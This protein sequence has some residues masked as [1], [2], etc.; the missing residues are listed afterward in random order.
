M[1]TRPHPTLP[2]AGYLR[3]LRPLLGVALAGALHGRWASATVVLCV[4][5]SVLTLLAFLAMAAGYE[6]QLNSRGQDDVALVLAREA[7]AES[8]SRVPAE[9]AR[10]I[11]RW[12]ATHG[13]APATSAELAITVS[14][15]RLRPA[16]G[17][18]ARANVPLRG[19]GAAGRSL[20]AGYRLA[21][22]REPAPGRQELMAGA[23][24][25]QELA[26]LAVGSRV[27][28]AGRDW[29]V[30]GHFELAGA[31]F[32]GELWADIGA[33]QAAYGRGNEL[34]SVR[35]A[36][37][38]PAE[39]EAALA[40]LDTMLAAEPGPALA[41]VTERA[42][43]ARQAEGTSRL[44]TLLAWPLAVLL[45]VG[46]VAG[47][48]ATLSMAVRSRRAGL[49]AL[50]QLGYSGLAVATSVVAE[51]L[52]LALAG[53]LLAFAI[54]LWWFDGLAARGLGAGLTSLRYEWQLGPA[55]LLQALGLAVAIALAGSIGPART[56][57]SLSRGASS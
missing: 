36:L 39:R 20:R 2:R 42:F 16:T 28:L 11:E 52:V 37:G 54:G 29:T 3:Q 1:D 43:Y 46:T 35:M 24:L 5:L 56:S 15:P 44:I 10:R 30:V 21:A 51:A 8:A 31:V 34:Q 19:L 26:G 6:R 47:C 4:M 53:A 38:A 55:G 13:G 17:E 7:S 40:R 41:A 22:G 12:A 33:V 49:R 45:S 23:R 14:L 18:P 48:F 50:H 27:R 25:A 9:A 32:E 57:L